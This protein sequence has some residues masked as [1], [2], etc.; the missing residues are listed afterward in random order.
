MAKD[1]WDDGPEPDP[2]ATKARQLLSLERQ[3]AALEGQAKGI[4]YEIAREF[5][6][7]VGVF[8]KKF[9]EVEVI[10]KRTERWNWDKNILRALINAKPSTTV[11]KEVHRA[12]LDNVSFHKTAFGRLSP[13]AQDILRA[14]LTVR[15]GP[16]TIEVKDEAEAT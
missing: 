13:E 7:G 9:D 4:S 1:E 10:L 3:I 16:F 8:T 11:E 14:A 5:P 12:V 6:A 15:D 2:L